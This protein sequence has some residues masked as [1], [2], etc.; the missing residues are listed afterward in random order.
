MQRGGA[1][2]QMACRWGAPQPVRVMPARDS[3][4]HSVGFSPPPSPARGASTG[5]RYAASPLTSPA[6]AV[7]TLAGSGIGR[8]EPPSVIAFSLEVPG[9]SVRCYPGAH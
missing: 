2:I 1:G 9:G 5:M 7:R 3:R 4:R 6:S 8:S